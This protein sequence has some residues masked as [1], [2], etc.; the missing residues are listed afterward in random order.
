MKIYVNKIQPEKI[1]VQT[2]F[3][4]KQVHSCFETKDRTKFENQHDVIY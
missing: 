4:G 3:P 1:K 2:T